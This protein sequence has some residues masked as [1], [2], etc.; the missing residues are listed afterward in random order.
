MLPHPQG[1]LPPPRRPGPLPKRLRQRRGVQGEQG[2]VPLQLRA[3]RA[4]KFPGAPAADVGG[5]VGRGVEVYVL[6]CFYLCVLFFFLFFS[7]A[8]FA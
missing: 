4:R 7:W 2:E 1:G 8:G 3:A 5:V 6:A